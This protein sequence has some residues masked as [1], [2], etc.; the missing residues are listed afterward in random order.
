MQA[1]PSGLIS[2]ATPGLV[3]GM[4]RQV[5]A[6]PHTNRPADPMPVAVPPS[7]PLCAVVSPLGDPSRDA[8]NGWI[9]GEASQASRHPL[10]RD[11]DDSKRRCPGAVPTPE[12]AVNG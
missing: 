6:V 1:D 8:R 2:A 7:R 9:C 5:S 4:H 11:Q 12:V 3:D 10:R